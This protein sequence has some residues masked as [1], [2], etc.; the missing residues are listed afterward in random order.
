MPRSRQRLGA[1]IIGSDDC[2]LKGQLLA[3]WYIPQT[4]DKRLSATC[5]S[6]NCIKKSGTATA[7]P[8]IWHYF[9]W[10]TTFGGLSG[11]C[12]SCKTVPKAWVAGK[13]YSL[14]S[15]KSVPK[16]MIAGKVLNQFPAKPFKRHGLQENTTR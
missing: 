6:L 15:C 9:R 3:A 8:F 12:V 5:C 1:T 2:P 10:L 7:V 14:I 13:Y 16:V 4:T 11:A